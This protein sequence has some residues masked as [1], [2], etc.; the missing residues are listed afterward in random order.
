MKEHHK[1][2]GKKDIAAHHKAMQE[3]LKAIVK[4]YGDIYSAIAAVTDPLTQTALTQILEYFNAIRKVLKNHHDAMAKHHKKFGAKLA[5]KKSVLEKK[6][7]DHHKAIQ[8]ELKAIEK[9]HGDIAP[10]IANV[11]DPLIQNALTQIL[12]YFDAVRKLLH[13]H[14][15]YMK[16]HHK[17]SL[18]KNLVARHSAIK[19]HH[20]EMLK[21]FAAIKKEYSDIAPSIAK[22]TDPLAKNAL[23]QIFEY[24]DAVRKLLQEHHAYIKTHGKKDIAAHHKAM[25][26]ELKA[27]AKEYGDIA[28]AIAAVTDPL[29]KSAL[30]QIFEYFD[31][32]HKVLKKH[33]E[34][35]AKL[36]KKHWRRSGRLSA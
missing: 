6:L 14:H 17:T 30:T 33:H 28:Q 34:E 35:M 26:E 9:E 23:T 15:E 36:H 12:E 18:G 8:E 4:E 10:A 22:I 1:T 31:A 24:F 20:E 19:K 7:A 32:I 16:E 21:E 29:T 25:Q 5:D 27:I 13:D 2:H 3:E 11:T